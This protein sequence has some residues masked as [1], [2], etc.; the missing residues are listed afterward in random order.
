MTNTVSVGA[1]KWDEYEARLANGRAV[2][3]LPIG[4]LEQ[5]G[6]HMSMNVDVLLPTAVCERV[7]QHVNGL[8]MPGLAYGYKSQ[9]RSGGGNFFPGTTSLDGDTLTKTILDIIR[10]LSRHG[11]RKLVVLNGHYENSVFIVEGIDLA[12]RELKQIGI[13]DFK[14]MALSY[15]D[16]ISDPDIIN[17]LYPEGFYGWDIEHGGLFETSLMLTLYP[18]LVDM[19]KVAMH[20]PA[21]FPPYDVYPV[22]ESRTP[23]SGTLSSA[24]NASKEKGGLILETCVKG[25]VEAVS[26]EFGVSKNQPFGSQ[27]RKSAG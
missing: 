4:A 20:P 11:A 2:M 16:F 23:E 19:D 22:D 8:V 27:G 15:W 3:F 26:Y 7:A 1:L 12:L 14:I 6:H 17:T 9:Q 21:T 10:E 24:E 25:I 5:H 18:E 13:F